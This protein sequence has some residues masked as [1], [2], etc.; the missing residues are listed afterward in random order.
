MAY[1]FRDTLRAA[2]LSKLKGL[3][4]RYSPGVQYAQTLI[5]EGFI[6]TPFVFKGYEQNSQW[7]DPQVPLRQ[8]DHTAGQSTIQTSSLKVY[9]A[10]IIDISH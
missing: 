4:F 5:D 3:K 8:V 2:E 1:D 9:G 6:G 7:L 10:Q